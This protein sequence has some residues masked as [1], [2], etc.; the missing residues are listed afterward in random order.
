MSKTLDQAI[1][2]ARRLPPEAQ[3]KIAKAIENIAEEFMPRYRLTPEQQEQVKES[4][5]QAKR[6]ELLEWDDVKGELA[7]KF[8]S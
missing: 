7:K 3:E 6:G 4:L 5:A 2:T 1:E 8:R